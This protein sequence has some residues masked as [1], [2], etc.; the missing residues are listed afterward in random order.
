MNDGKDKTGLLVSNDSGVFYIPEEELGRYRLP[1]D[2]AA[3][4]SDAAGDEVSG[5]AQ[6]PTIRSSSFSFMGSFSAAQLPCQYSDCPV[7]GAR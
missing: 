2:V 7:A 4:V 1:D 5:F 3:G 6:R